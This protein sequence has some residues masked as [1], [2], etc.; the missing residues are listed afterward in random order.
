MRRPAEDSPPDRQAGLDLLLPLLTAHTADRDLLPG[1]AQRYL[2]R[3]EDYL[4]L[5]VRIV[6]VGPERTQTLA[7]GV[8]AT[9]TRPVDR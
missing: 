9:R 5:P 6:S 3:I 4:G 1:A 8:V 7:S 2:A